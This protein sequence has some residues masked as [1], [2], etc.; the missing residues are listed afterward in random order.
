MAQRA[1]AGDGLTNSKA[2]V[3][4]GPTSDADDKA[5]STA[6]ATTANGHG[7]KTIFSATTRTP[8]GCTWSTSTTAT[9]F[10]CIATKCLP[11]RAACFPDPEENA[12]CSRGSKGSK[13]KA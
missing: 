7:A 13:G 11:T 3:G 8:S 12:K 2:E 10:I 9:A 4:D 5:S 6:T 1:E